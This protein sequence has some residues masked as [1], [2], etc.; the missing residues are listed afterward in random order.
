M[1]RTCPYG[2]CHNSNL[3]T[4]N[5][6]CPACSRPI[7]FMGGHD[8]TE[9]V[10]DR[11][12][13][14]TGRGWVFDKMEAWLTA[15]PRSGD[16]VFFLCGGPGSGKSSVAA[17]LVQLARG[18]APAACP[19]FVRTGLAYYHFCAAQYDAVIEPAGFVKSLS[20]ALADR[21]PPFAEALTRIGK[22]HPEI[23]VQQTVGQV[24]GG[25]IT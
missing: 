12:R 18:E 22:D 7:Y 9:L 10:V 23:Y 5:R 11:T 16:R 15:P 6:S 25:A 1:P 2:D 24:T 13:D 17:R 4:N 20:L 8:Y 21:Y 14:F 19:H 3:A